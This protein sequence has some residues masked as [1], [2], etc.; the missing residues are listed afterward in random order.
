MPKH[1]TTHFLKYFILHG[2][3]GIPDVQINLLI[4]K[5]PPSASFPILGN[6]SGLFPSPGQ[7]LENPRKCSIKG[8]KLSEADENP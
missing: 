8:I 1:P 4:M 6:Q 2:R 5:Q 3:V 7:L